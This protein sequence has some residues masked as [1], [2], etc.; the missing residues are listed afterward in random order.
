MSRFLVL[1]AFFIASRAL[2][3]TAET[4]P[5]TIV[6]GSCIQKLEHDSFDVILSLNP[7]LVVLLGDTIYL[8]DKLEDPYTEGEKLYGALSHH[9]E[10]KKLRALSTVMGTWDDHDFG[11][12]DADSVF[13]Y[14][15]SSLKLFREFWG[16]LPPSPFQLPSVARAVDL[17]SVLLLITDGRSFRR[18]EGPSRT[19][20]GEE[21]LQWML[22]KIKSFKG[23]TIVIASGTQW[24][25]DDVKNETLA[26]FPLEKERLLSALDSSSKRVI[27]ISG[28]RHRAE[29]YQRKLSH[30]VITEITSSPLAGEVNT[31]P[32]NHEP[33][34]VGVYAGGPNVG[35]LKIGE[36]NLEGGIVNNKGERV[37]TIP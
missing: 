9:R 28:D 10:F 7:D 29:L 16:P 6:F 30:S 19:M 33:W 4:K 36:G 18:N 17:G 3:S 34:R 11:T 5:V 15:D 2:P 23:H 27:I 26:R 20:F 13:P 1:L 37:L 8:P 12:N 24:L 32:L 35:I 31:S 14:K 21:Q 22:K 25:S